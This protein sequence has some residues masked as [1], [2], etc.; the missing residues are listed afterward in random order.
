MIR[1]SVG[2]FS[3]HISGFKLPLALNE[4]RRV[5]KEVSNVLKRYPRAGILENQSRFQMVMLIEID[6]DAEQKA[7]SFWRKIVEGRFPEKGRKEICL[8][9][10][11]A[12]TLDLRTGD[13]IAFKKNPISEP[14]VLTVSGMFHTG[15]ERLDREMAFCPMEATGL[16]METWDAAVFLKAGA[17]VDNVMKKYSHLRTGSGQFR[18]WSELMPDLK[19]LI[20][21]N[22]LS[23]SIVAVL[24]FGV[25]S[26]GIACAFAI[27]ILK[28][29][30]EY[31]IM[32]AMGVT[33]GETT[34]LIFVEVILMNLAASFLGILA[35]MG[36]VYIAGKSGI[37][38]SAYTS[39]NQYF[40]VS[41]VIYPRLTLYSLCLPPA[42]ALVF[43]LFAAVWPAFLVIRKKPADILR[44]L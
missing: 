24:V 32:K 8:S 14:V 21:L 34:F 36:S 40:V 9:R 43:S 28:N 20:A 3:G 22:Y 19:Q 38:L 7:T 16:N 39:H 29:L 31:G 44:S 1:N 42:L 13:K 35:G 5:T 4:S 17:R 25:V 30:R 37:D 33:P 23:M 41:G 6:P 15:I 11:T 12:K 2:L 27:F 10:Q 18:S 26:I